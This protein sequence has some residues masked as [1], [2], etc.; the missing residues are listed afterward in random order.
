MHEEDYG[1]AWKHT[2]FRTGEVEVRRSRRLVISLI[3]T[4]GNYE[5]GFFWYLYTDGSIEY[6]I[7][8]PASSPRARVAPGEQPAAR[9][10]WSRPASTARTTST[11]STCGST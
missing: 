1:I 3:A 9:R 2:D 6:E 4:V 7:K 5:Y 11:S 10:R 8:L